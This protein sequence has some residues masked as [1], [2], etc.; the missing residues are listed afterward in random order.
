MPKFYDWKLESEVM[1]S[2]DN[3]VY[4]RLQHVLLY[5]WYNIYVK[6]LII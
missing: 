6:N 3:L 1:Q 4:E 2:K 5:K